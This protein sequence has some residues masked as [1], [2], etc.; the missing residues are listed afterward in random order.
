[1]S[2]TVEMYGHRR[3]GNSHGDVFTSPEMVRFMLD[4]AGYIPE[5]DLS[6]VRI[7]EPSCGMGDFLSE[8]QDRIIASSV[9]FGF[10]ALRVMQENI[11]ACEID[12]SKY[13]ACIRRLT[14]RMP[15]LS[16]VNVRNEDFLLSRWNVSFDL[17][18]GNPPYVRYENIPA[19][20]RDIYKSLFRTFHY[21]CDLYVLFYEHSLKLLSRGGRHCFICSNRW[22]KNEYGRKLRDFISSSFDLKRLVDVE[23]ADVFQE[24]VLAYPVVSLIQNTH[25]RDF[26]ETAKVSNVSQLSGTIVF[27]RMKAPSGHDWSGL[28]WDNELFALRTIEQQGFNIGIG[29]ATGADKVFISSSLDKLIEPE[30]LLPLINAR[31]LTGNAFKWDGRYLLNPYDS[32]GH[33]VNLEDYPKAM[34]YLCD[35]RD[36]LEH[37]HIVRNNRPWFSLIDRIK[38]NLVRQPKVLLPD[39]SGNSI[40]FVDEGRFYPAHNLYYVVGGDNNEMRLLASILMSSFVKNQIA[41]ISNKMNG[42]YPRWQSQSIKKLRIPLISTLKEDYKTRL[43]YAYETSNLDMINIMVDRIIRESVHERHFE[44]QFFQPSLFD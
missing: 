27:K 42:G 3:N 24:D 22:L 43:L 26:V 35:R 15:G 39:I 36:K 33:L 12:Q 10:D 8:I 17:I 5:K 30:L 29:V 19:G 4:T 21:R 11:Y 20:K 9:N 41:G 18:V 6:K 44:P 16:L 38:P 13:H 14:E 23:D 32:Q 25:K 2:S 1:M 34:K 31:N 37:R 40:I 28:F 7:L